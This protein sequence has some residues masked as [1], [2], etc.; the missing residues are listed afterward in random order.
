MKIETTGA[1]V[2]NWT[3]KTRSCGRGDHE[4]C[5]IDDP[6]AEPWLRRNG[7]FAASVPETSF[8]NYKYQIDID[9]VSN[10]WSGLFQKLL[11]GSPVLK[12]SSPVGFGNGIVAASNPG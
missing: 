6:D 8:G 11:T 12:V 4:V 10:S 5:H 7:L 1:A 2:R 9:G 3:A